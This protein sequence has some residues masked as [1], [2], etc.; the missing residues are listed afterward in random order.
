[1][2][3]LECYNRFPSPMTCWH[4][5]R[6]S[7]LQSNPEPYRTLPVA[8]GTRDLVTEMSNAPCYTEV[9]LVRPRPRGH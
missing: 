7:L 5:D 8:L 2:S 6:N 4:L 1:M 3:I 9:S